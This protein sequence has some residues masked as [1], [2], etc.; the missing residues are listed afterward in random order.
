MPVYVPPPKPAIVVKSDD[1]RG[2]N[3]LATCPAGYKAVPVSVL[4]VKIGDIDYVDKIDEILHDT[5]TENKPKKQA[6]K[7]HER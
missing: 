3:F 2:M 1:H 5:C 6:Q 7:Q 4:S